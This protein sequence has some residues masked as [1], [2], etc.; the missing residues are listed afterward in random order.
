MKIQEDM[1]KMLG[2]KSWEDVRCNYPNSSSIENL[3]HLLL[4]TKRFV[5]LSYI[6]YYLFVIQFTYIILLIRII[7]FSMMPK[8]G[9]VP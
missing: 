6:L 9:T 3:K 1:V 5:D 8:K 7:L 2:E 4:H